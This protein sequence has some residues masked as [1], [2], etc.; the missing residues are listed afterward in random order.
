MSISGIGEIF[1]FGSKIIDKIF[2]NKDE[3]DKAKIKLIE[4]QQAGELA[5]L[6]AAKQQ[7][8]NQASINV[9]EAQNSSIFVSGWRPAIGWICATAIGYA[10]IIQPLLSWIL[11]IYKPE[12]KP[13]QFPMDHIFELLF[14]MLGLGGLRS[15]EKI[16]GVSTQKIKKSK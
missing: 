15:Y 8:A 11:Y 14:G 2:P 5:F 13:P 7:D 3:A 12:L 6:D 9:A 1:E 10:Y 16:K 4:L